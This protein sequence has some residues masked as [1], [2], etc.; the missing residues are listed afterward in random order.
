[1]TVNEKSV[2]IN[3]SFI[4]RRKRDY[5]AIK[6]KEDEINA[7]Y[8]NVNRGNI[9]ELKKALNEKIEQLNALESTKYQYGRPE[10]IE[11][12]LMYRHCLLYSEVAKDIA[13]INSN[14]SIRFYIKDDVKEAEKTKKLIEERKLA[15][16]NFVELDGT[17][18]K[19]NAVYTAIAVLNGENLIEALLKDRSLKS[20]II[21]DYA[22]QHPDKFN[23]VYS[24]KHIMTKAL[25]ETLISRGELIRSEFNQQISTADGAFVGA[26]LNEAVAYFDNPDNSTVRTAYE[27]KLKLF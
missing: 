11:E 6:A 7:R 12:Y 5:L 21:M 24:D 1:M 20:S 4:Y 10:N 9:S 19:F 26:N 25:V 16:R 15:M 14:P 13:L 18:A 8:D 27:N 2:V 3:T 17:E 23:K 22:N